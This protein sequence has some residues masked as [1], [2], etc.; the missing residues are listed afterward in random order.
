MHTWICT[1]K[2]ISYCISIVSIAHVFRFLSAHVSQALW[3]FLFALEPSMFALN[4][5]CC[6]ICALVWTKNTSIF[7]CQTESKHMKQCEYK[8]T[9]ITRNAWA[10]NFLCSPSKICF[11]CCNWAKKSGTSRVWLCDSYYINF[12]TFISLM[13]L[14]F[15]L[16]CLPLVIL[17][18]EA[19][20]LQ[21]LGN[22][23]HPFYYRHFDEYGLLLRFMQSTSHP[24][25]TRFC[26][27]TEKKSFIPSLVRFNAYYL[28]MLAV[29]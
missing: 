10:I 4:Y 21:P 6:H 26:M 7:F 15:L 1:I 29:I 28:P 11:Y 3:F 18:L 22:T 23:F 13:H 5:L 17:S 27:Q 9:L 25:N 24:L 12:R 2:S 20:Y 14:H 8:V 19:R 16:Y